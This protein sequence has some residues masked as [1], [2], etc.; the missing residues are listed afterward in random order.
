[1]SRMVVAT[2]ANMTPA[3]G[4]EE[5][6]SA[7]TVG[8]GGPAGVQTVWASQVWLA[9]GTTFTAVR[10]ELRPPVLGASGSAEGLAEDLRRHLYRRARP[11]MYW[12]GGRHIHTGGHHLIKQSPCRIGSVQHKEL[13]DVMKYISQSVVEKSGGP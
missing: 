11:G 4:S 1:M 12:P 10:E 7:G 8:G 6:N 5:R 3:E 13:E 2:Q 9:Q